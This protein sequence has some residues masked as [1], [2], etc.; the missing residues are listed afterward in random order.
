[1]EQSFLDPKALLE[2]LRIDHDKHEEEVR[3][4]MKMSENDRHELIYRMFFRIAL[5]FAHLESLVTEV[6]QSV[7][8]ARRGPQVM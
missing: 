4:F 8:A 7:A 3:D 5:H 6:D 2:S 1:M